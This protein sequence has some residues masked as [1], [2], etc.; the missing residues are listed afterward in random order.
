MWSELV[1]DRNVTSHVY[2]ESVSTKVYQKIR[3]VYCE[4]L[5][6]LVE[7]LKSVQL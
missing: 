6:G 7:Y 5:R 4:E 2:A 3:D 1:L